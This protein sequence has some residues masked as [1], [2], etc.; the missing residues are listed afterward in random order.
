MQ[1]ENSGPKPKVGKSISHSYPPPSQLTTSRQPQGIKTSALRCVWYLDGGNW[2]T[3]VKPPA[4]HII[5][6]LAWCEDTAVMP[7]PGTP[8][9]TF[10]PNSPFMHTLVSRREIRM[11]EGH[12]PPFTH[13]I[14]PLLLKDTT[15]VKPEV[16]R[17]KPSISWGTRDG[18]QVAN[19]LF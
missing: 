12:E 16:W 11:L 14:W 19:N 18:E 9:E 3:L 5:V 2:E 7:F 1:K 4:K 10:N 15:A 17:R 13:L 8:Q 6:L